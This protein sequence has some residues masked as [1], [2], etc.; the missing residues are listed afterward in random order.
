MTQKNR[1]KV[2]I[3]DLG[4]VV[5]NWDV[6]RI[7]NSLGLETQEL[8]LLRSE[9][10]NHQHW[11]DLD[12]G[13]DT[14]EGVISKIC[15]RSPLNRE[16]VEKAILA[17]KNSLVPFDETV[18]LMREVSDSGIEMLCLSNMS[19]ETYDHI[20]HYE[21]FEWFDGIVISGI[22]KCI[23]PNE[24]IFHLIINRYDLIPA[25]TLFIDDS[26]P[27]IDTAN[28]LGINAFHFKRSPDCYSAIRKMLF[29]EHQMQ[30]A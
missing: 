24:D 6:E 25:G 7:L 23:K 18:S 28:R 13:L 27:N 30:L 9:L 4:N 29:S 15:L 10:F 26:K 17:A 8:E 2:V 22:E 11:V 14:E 16:V 3:F 12:H 21:F 20:K 1:D 5:L 19:E